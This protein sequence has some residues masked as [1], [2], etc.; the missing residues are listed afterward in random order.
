MR[1]KTLS[2]RPR[3]SVDKVAA[4]KL[5]EALLAMADA[6]GSFSPALLLASGV[7][8]MGAVGACLIR[9]DSLAPDAGAEPGGK[10][11]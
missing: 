5:A 4:H 3:T 6:A 8:L 9:I 2:M 11:G 7:A 1:L 10:A